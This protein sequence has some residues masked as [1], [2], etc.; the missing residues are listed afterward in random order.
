MIPGMLMFHRLINIKLE[1]RF[2]FLKE[3]CFVNGFK[4]NTNLQTCVLRYQFV[5]T[6]HWDVQLIRYLNI[7]IRPTRPTRPTRKKVKNGDD[8]T[9]VRSIKL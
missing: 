5:H 9:T 1:Q 3:P 4:K 6:K 8:R 2:F 7:T